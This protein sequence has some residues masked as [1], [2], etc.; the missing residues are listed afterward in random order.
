MATSTPPTVPT[1]EQTAAVIAAN[2][3]QLHTLAS[4]EALVV[5]VYNE[6]AS[7][8]TDGPLSE[9]AVR[10][11]KD[12]EAAAKAIVAATEDGVAPPPNEELRTS[13]V[14]PVQGTLNSQENILSFL[15]DIESTLAAT[16]ITA[17]A[18]LS[19]A[20]DRQLVMTYAAACANR[21]TVLGNNGEGEIPIAA[22]F[23]TDYLIPGAAYLDLTEEGG[24]ATGADGGAAGAGSEGN[25]GDGD[26]T[27]GLPEGESN[28]AD[29]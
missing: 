2:Q 5:E 27:N 19:E 11:G 12:H 9:A 18:V 26:Q 15:R 25:T 10:F 7:T 17:T 22:R 16:Y 4:V 28:T 21:V 6:N 1:P 29:N 24:D 3:S 20:A 13:M 23:P 14:D 8:I